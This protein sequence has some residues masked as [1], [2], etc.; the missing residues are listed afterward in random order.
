MDA[1]CCCHRLVSI[2][3]A[4]VVNWLSR[5][6]GVRTYTYPGA[7]KIILGKWFVPFCAT[8]QYINLV[9]TGIGYTVTAGIAM[10]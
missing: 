1:R 6:T 9:G 3:S 5:D 7:V 4:Q 2:N 8:I 10:V